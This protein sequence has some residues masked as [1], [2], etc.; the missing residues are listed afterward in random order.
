MLRRI[1]KSRRLPTPVLVDEKHHALYWTGPAYLYDHM[2]TWKFEI[3]ILPSYLPEKKSSAPLVLTVQ[4]DTKW[5]SRFSYN[6]HKLT[7]K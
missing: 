2:N 3:L 4:K 7:G 5:F 1:L 6:G